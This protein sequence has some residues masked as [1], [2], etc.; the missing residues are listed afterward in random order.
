M[1]TP[2]CRGG[3]RRRPPSAGRT[4]RQKAE[5]EPTRRPAGGTP[6]ACHPGSRQ[7]AKGPSPQ[8]QLRDKRPGQSRPA[9]Q[10][11]RPRPTPRLLARGGSA[12]RCRR[13]EVLCPGRQPMIPRRFSM[14]VGSSPADAW[15][16]THHHEGGT[17]H[18][19]MGARGGGC[20]RGQHDPPR[21]PG[22]ALLEAR[23]ATFVAPNGP[24]P[25]SLEVS[26]WTAPKGP[27]GATFPNRLTH[28]PTFA[29][30]RW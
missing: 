8:A 22:S 20:F 2:R 11:P 5:A 27:P 21:Q 14:S 25:A 7:R 10:R 18:H 29:Q 26:L 19:G 1:S 28:S 3:G 15:R 17:V 16:E 4:S 23:S 12:R 24:K 13:T 9:G 6:A 30:V